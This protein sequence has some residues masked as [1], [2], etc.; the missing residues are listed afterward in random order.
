M[1]PLTVLLLGLALTACTRPPEESSA[2]PAPD[3]AQTQ[4]IRN[5]EAVGVAGD[6]VADQVDAALDANEARKQKLDAEL[7]TQETP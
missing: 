5:T 7:E 6:A 1:R 4:P 2:A 3:R